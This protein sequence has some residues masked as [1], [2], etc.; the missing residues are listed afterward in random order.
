[1]PTLLAL[2]LA[3][4]MACPRAAFGQEVPPPA[5]PFS[6][7]HGPFLQLPGET[8]IVVTWHTNR[9][10]V[11][12]VE[13]GTTESLG[14]TAVSAEHGLVE[15]RRASHVVRLTG[16]K[17]GTRYYYRVVSREFLGYEKQHIV[18]W[19]ESVSGAIASFT[20]LDAHAGDFSFTVVCDIHENE[21]RFET[22]V[23][24]AERVAPAAFVAFN[25]D[26]VNDFMNEGQP[27]A[28]FLDASGRLFA[29]ERP[30]VYV[31]GNHDVRGRFARTLA[32]YFPTAD[33]RAYY[34]FDHGGVHVVVLDSGEDKKDDHQ[35]YNGLVA[36]ERYR[37]EQAEWLAR[38]L[39]SPA[40][41]RARFRV[42]LSHVPPRGDE[43]FAIDAVR[44]LWEGIANRGKVDLWLSGHTHKA[45]TVA[46]VKGANRYH[47][48][49]GAPTV[50]TH[51][52]VTR[53]GLEVI[54]LGEDGKIV[55]RM[56][57]AK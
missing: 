46:P 32:D 31:R 57:V 1:M 33:G 50:A 48:V 3:V 27:F 12:R 18:K 40:A 19:G 36:F 9:P 37:E 35:Y 41:R 21:K 15:N 52:K 54:Q 26:M 55:G 39:A 42:V 4:L 20:T 29:R 34:S 8:S 13:Y 23:G 11:S 45:A 43:G 17:P 47:L 53:R 51:V 5:A 16:L 6:V 7:S 22:L 38:D 14:L 56:E 28:G 49:V 30:I 2:C 10:A 24:H 25:G 44:R